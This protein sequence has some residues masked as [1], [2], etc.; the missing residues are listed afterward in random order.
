MFVNDYR[1]ACTFTDLTN[2]AEAA[3][4]TANYVQNKKRFYLTNNA[5]CICL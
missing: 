3:S 4:Y 2:S 5:K 1:F